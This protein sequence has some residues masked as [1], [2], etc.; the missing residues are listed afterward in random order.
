MKKVGKR[1]FIES[2][3]FIESQRE[4]NTMMG[5]E[6]GRRNLNCLK[7]FI[8]CFLI[9]IFSILFFEKKT[10]GIIL[11]IGYTIMIIQYIYFEIKNKK[12]WDNFYN[13]KKQNPIK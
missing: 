11:L 3:K 13:N 6:I 2:R 5:D 9:P 8:L 1:E 10:V 12:K 4:F 7:A